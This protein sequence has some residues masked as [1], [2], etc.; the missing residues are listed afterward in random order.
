VAHFLPRAAAL[1]VA[2]L[3]TAAFAEADIKAWT[4][5]STPRLAAS[6]LQGRKLDLKDYRGRVVVLNFW[7]TWCVPCRD[8][9][10]SLQRLR[11][12]LEGKP[13]EVLTVNYGE[14]P[15]KIEPYVAQEQIT[16]PVML[17]TQKEIAKDWKVGGLPMTFVIDAKGRVRYWVFGER[18]WS[19]GESLKLVEKL[20]NEG[21]RARH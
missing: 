2:A 6:D 4:G 16:L 18:D 20:I 17:D 10:P 21:A 1:A 11:A 7:A 5:K 14:F 8:E 3:A 15:A 13:F 19:R 9:L 12:N